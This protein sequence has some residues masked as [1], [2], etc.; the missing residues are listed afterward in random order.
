MA[1]NSAPS[2]LQQHIQKFLDEFM[3]VE[4]KGN[5]HIVA[6]KHYHEVFSELIPKYFIPKDNDNEHS[7]T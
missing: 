5:E 4:Y 2:A 7:R 1:H 6:R 3:R